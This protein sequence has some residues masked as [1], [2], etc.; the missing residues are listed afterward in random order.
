MS[1]ISGPRPEPCWRQPRLLMR[2]R[3]AGSRSI[4]RA[5]SRF[6]QTL[7]YVV[8]F[9]TGGGYFGI[10]TNFFT[11]GGV[12]N[13]PLQALS[14][15]VAGGD[16]VYGRSG[17]FPNVDSNGMNFW[18]DVAF[19]PS[20]GSSAT[21]AVPPAGARIAVIGL[22][23][24]ALTGTSQPTRFATATPAGPASSFGGW[25]AGA[26]YREWFAGFAGTGQPGG[27]ACVVL[28]EVGFRERCGS[29]S[30]NRSQRRWV[31]ASGFSCMQELSMRTGTI[32][33]KAAAARPSGRSA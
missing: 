11:A 10:N 5:R 23:M 3:R 9:S 24:G 20:S 12:T 27:D 4:S 14:N 32:S 19:S 25:R 33:V 18:A 16:G 28:Q 31:R 22:G 26:H 8:S 6:S 2:R 17:A 21:K 30:L 15:S 29:E 7:E 1:A 13:G